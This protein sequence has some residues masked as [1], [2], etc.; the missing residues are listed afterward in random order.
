MT[1][2][3]I[4]GFRDCPL[5]DMPMLEVLRQA[6]ER[7]FVPL[8]VGGGIRGFTA[9][10]K[11]YSALEVAS[12]YFRSGADKI[13]I[14][15]DAVEVAEQYIARGTAD[16]TS[17]IEQISDVYGKQAVVVSIDPRRVYVA[18]PSSVK[19]QTVKTSRPGPNGEQYCWWQCTVKGGR[20]G[21]DIGAVELAKAVEALGAGEILLNC[22]DNDGA[23]KVCIAWATH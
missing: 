15:S 7:V 9:G 4:T 10:G 19:H 14:G 2:L 18:D 5:A 22:I 12:E 13:S 21:R 17:S 23:G 3:N 16:G 1:F 20:E 11:T 8:T 6:S